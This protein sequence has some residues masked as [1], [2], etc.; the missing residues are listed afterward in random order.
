L[1]ATLALVATQEVVASGPRQIAVERFIELPMDVRHPESI[2]SNDEARELYVGTFDARTPD[3]LRN[4]QLLRFSEGGKL[5]ARRSFGAT[6]LTGIQFEKGYVYVL[7]FGASRLQKIRADFDATTTVDDVA[8]FRPL[9]VP[10]P[11]PRQVPNPD[12]SVDEIKFGSAG[13]PAIN[14]MVFDRAG[15]LY[16]SDSFQ[17]AI[18]RISNATNCRECEVETISRDPLLATAGALPFGANGLA[19]STNESSLYINN[20]GDGRVLRMSLPD[21]KVTVLANSIYGADGLMMHNGVLW[22]AANQSDAVV[23][24]DEHGRERFRAGSFLG[25]DG[26]GAPNGLLFPASTAVLGDWMIVANLSLPLTPNPGDEWEED[27]T[28]WTLARFKLP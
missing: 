1:I 20:A 16:V 21:G 12:G 5:L 25:I 19:L 18:Y 24:I 23:G 13:L 28:R 9:P 8:I 2:T 22:V 3:S 26:N 17:G 4:N 11:A 15:N 10:S 27:V 6:P 14:G 7:N